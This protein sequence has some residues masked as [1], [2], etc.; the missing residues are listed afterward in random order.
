MPATK[1]PKIPSIP[2]PKLHRYYP[3]DVLDALQM[4][5]ADL[6]NLVATEEHRNLLLKQ[7]Y[8]HAL[9]EL[10]AQDV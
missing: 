6:T 3:Q 2:P 4:K 1:C 10:S 7:Q 5:Y 9:Q 8:K